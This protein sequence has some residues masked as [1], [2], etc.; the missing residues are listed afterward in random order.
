VLREPRPEAVFVGF[1][2]SNLDLQLRL[3]VDM[4]ALD[5]RWMTDLH[6]AI[7][8]LFREQGIE[9]AFPQRDVNLKLASPLL[10]LLQRDGGRLAA[11]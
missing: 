8:R 11:E 10:E 1:L 2:D 7:E 9:M 6:Q 3:F 4:S 5:W